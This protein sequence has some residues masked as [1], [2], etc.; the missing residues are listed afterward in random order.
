MFL[1]FLVAG[2]AEE[3][4]WSGYALDA[5]S[6]RWSA[7]RAS[8]FLGVV[9]ALWHVPGLMEVGRTPGW[10][11]WWGLGT[12]GSRVIIVWLYRNTESVFAASVY[13]AL[14]NFCWQLFDVVRRAAR[15]RRARRRQGEPV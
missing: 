2:A 7:L 3:L 13:H 10:I 5:V 8:I 4:G 15:S 6:E 12:V 1:V 14:I 9:W 11:A